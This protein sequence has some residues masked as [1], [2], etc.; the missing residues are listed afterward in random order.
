MISKVIF[1]HNY[2]LVTCVV[3]YKWQDWEYYK[4][5]LTYDMLIVN[6]MLIVLVT[7]P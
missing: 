1:N 5:L 4:L 3:G 6:D 7:T 2:I